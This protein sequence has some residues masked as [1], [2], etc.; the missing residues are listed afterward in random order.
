VEWLW[1]DEAGGA[2]VE[3]EVLRSN[4]QIPCHSR[5]MRIAVFSTKSHDQTWLDRAN[6]AHGHELVYFD[7]RL[8]SRTA[9]LAAGFPG[10]CAFVNDE[11]DAGV[12]GTL[13]R[14]G[15]RLIALRSAGFNNVDLT[16][17]QD[18]GLVVVRVPAYSPHAV[19]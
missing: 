6:A 1:S 3:L 2:W 19:A 12:L 18:L 11:L 16:A 17:A 5:A 4:R 13:V 9:P 7:A 15:T 10:I 14:G 8:T